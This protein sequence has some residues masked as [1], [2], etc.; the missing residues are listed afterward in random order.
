MDSRSGRDGSKRPI[1]DIGG[2]WEAPAMQTTTSTTSKALLIVLA[3]PVAVF[4]GL[5]SWFL[6]LK[7]KLSA[8]DVA[9]SLRD[10]IEGTG[11]DWDWDDFTSVPI[12][13]SQLDDIRRRAAA[14]TG[15]LTEESVIVLRELLIEAEGLAAQ[16]T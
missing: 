10:H 11:A 3:F 14:V 8:T 7:A 5:L 16:E 4:A 1:A 12:A 9:K 6:N 13:N 2:I 15:P